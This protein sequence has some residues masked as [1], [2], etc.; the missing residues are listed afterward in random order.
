MTED[1]K[2]TEEATE[3][4]PQSPTKSA[5]SATDA[6][7]NR[8]QL[9]M[10]MPSIKVILESGGAASRPMLQ[11]ETSLT[12]RLDSWCRL[13][14]SVTLLMTYY[15]ER[16]TAWEPIIEPIDASGK[17]WC[18]EL[19]ATIETGDD[20]SKSGPKISAS[21]ES[22]DRLE[23]TVSKTFLSVVNRLGEAFAK[24]VKK[25]EKLSVQRDITQVVN[26]LGM[27]MM[28]IVDES[29][30]T[31]E[32]ERVESAFGY[33]TLILY[34]NEQVQ[35]TRCKPSTKT[36]ELTH[37]ENHH[38]DETGGDFVARLVLNGKEINRSIAL[39]NKCQKVFDIPVIRYPVSR[40]RCVI[41]VDIQHFGNKKVTFGTPIKLVNNL[42]RAIDVY[43]L[44][45]KVIPAVATDDV[46]GNNCVPVTRVEESVVKLSSVDAGFSWY[47]PLNLVFSETDVIFFSAGDDYC[48]PN[49]GVLFKDLSRATGRSLL[50]KCEPKSNDKPCVNLQV[51]SSTQDLLFEETNMRIAKCIILEINPTLVLQNLLPLPVKYTLSMCNERVLNQGE[52]HQLGQF[53]PDSPCIGI[54]IPNYLEK[55]WKCVKRVEVRNFDEDDVSVWSFAP[56]TVTS[57]IEETSP[58]EQHLVIAMSLSKPYPSKPVLAQLF[59]PFWLVNRTGMKLTLKSGDIIWNL[60]PDASLP[61]LF[62]FKAGKL[63]KQKLQMKIQESSWSDSFSIDAVGNQGNVLCRGVSGKS[64]DS[65]LESKAT[66]CVSI[67]IAL[68]SFSLTKIVTFSPFYSVINRTKVF[69]EVSDDQISWFPVNA[70]SKI[71]FWPKEVSCG[72]FFVRFNGF[73]S[74]PVSFKESNSTLITAGQDLLFNI[75]VDVT[76]SGVQIQLSDYDEGSCPVKIFNALPQGIEY[77]QQ[78]YPDRKNYLPSFHSVY[79]LWQEPTGPRHLVWKILDHSVETEETVVELIQDT[80]GSVE[81]KQESKEN[82]FWVSFLDGRQRTLLISKD[83]GL[84]TAALQAAEFTQPNVTLDVS[85]KGLGVSVVNDDLRQDLIYMGVSGCDTVWEVKKAGKTKR[86]KALQVKQM[87]VIEAAYKRELTRRKIQAEENLPPPTT[88]S[89]QS[90]PHKIK[91]DMTD[92]HNIVMLEPVRGVLRRYSSPG[93]FAKVITSDHVVQVH[94]KINRIQIDNQQDNCLFNIIMCPVTPPK[95]LSSDRAPK[96]FIEFSTVLQKTA[97]LNRFKYLSVL[98]QEFLVQIDGAFLLSISDFFGAS[99]YADKEI[100]YEKLISKD[101]K[102]LTDSEEINDESEVILSRAYYDLI[103]FSPIK[104]HVSFSLGG[105]S[106][107]QVFGVLDLLL[108]SA[109]VTLTEFKDV[110]FKIDFFERKNILLDNQQLISQATTHYMRQVLKQFYVIV[111]GLDVIGNPVGLVLGLKQGVGDFFYEPFMGIIEG[112]EEFAEGLALGVKS[113]FSHTFGGAAGALSKITGTLGEGVSALTM[114]DEF[115]RRRRMRMQRK[116]NVAESGKELAQGFWRGLTG[117][118]RKPIEGARDDGL[119]GLVKGI[120]KG[121]VG[122]LAQP[123][124]GVIDF[125]SGSLGA[126]RRAVDINA[127]AKRQRPARFFKPDNILRPYNRHEATGNQMLQMLDKGSFAST[128]NYLTHCTLI[129]PA[130]PSRE[131]IV[132]ITD[133]RVFVLKDSALYSTLEIEWKEDFLDI[134]SIDIHNLQVIKFLL[135]VSNFSWIV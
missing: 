61:L 11:F 29:K 45:T 41:D 68:S 90:L 99:S 70:T 21:L 66:Y 108:R 97:N 67:D 56:V 78:G 133:H 110:T 111:L 113:L 20:A 34:P 31:F 129:H 15:N 120:G 10:K 122:V 114:D 74:C 13:S 86:W 82:I 51:V 65:R 92:V 1:T 112:P 38:Q 64:R 127:E 116:Q 60:P 48:I 115:I 2:L 105:V 39:K 36:G 106:S 104:V 62:S 19:K 35:L 25:S 125:A 42:Q 27:D 46:E 124:T 96:P 32:W 22:H 135:K 40:L 98:I 72:K 55:T 102:Q 50:I 107:F 95:S 8:D 7:D 88:S 4:T 121:A 126:L 91:V 3:V 37:R 57:S 63:F 89:I 73:V 12:G 132:L 30:Y 93:F 52:K 14:S 81:K 128:D 6:N 100:D 17:V 28:I 119:E 79:F 94:A 53:D 23:V 9:M 5:S 84:T 49:Q 134:Q 101:M 18:T 75:L 33:S 26:C 43:K 69:V 77:W 117:I 83:S 59:A 71:S 123:A 54:L 47:L 24:A 80:F 130:N 58:A 103:H 118:I 131:I 16:V 85:F 76:D 109:G 44:V 87:E